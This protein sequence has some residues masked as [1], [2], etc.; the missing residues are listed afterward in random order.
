MSKIYIDYEDKLVNHNLRD[1]INYLKNANNTNLNIPYGFSKANNVR[2]I[3]SSL[4]ATYNDLNNIL[5]WLETSQQNY[6]EF[7]ADS[8]QDVTKIERVKI[9]SASSIVR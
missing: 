4:N 8:I 1:A 6:S 7:V 2:Q 9:K 3:E 5:K